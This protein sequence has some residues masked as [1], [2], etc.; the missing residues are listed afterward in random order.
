VLSDIN[1]SALRFCR[2]NAALNGVPSA[3]IVESDLF[4]AV[5]GAFDL[6]IA[7]PPYLVDR[8]SRLY[9]H[10]GGQFGEGLSLKIAEQG[11]TRLAPGGRLVLYTGSAIVGGV[12]GLHEALRARVTGRGVRFTYEE[13]DPDVFGEEL[14][15]PP[16]DQ[17]DR[18][19]V[20]VATIERLPER[21]HS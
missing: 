2:I 11:L 1:R 15:H 5:E 6:I 18:I 21:G 12:D 3:T 14:A 4:G 19:A 7:N 20:V 9:R 16:Y 8:L 10:G 13:I 17:A